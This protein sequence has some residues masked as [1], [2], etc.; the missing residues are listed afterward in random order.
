MAIRK[1]HEKTNGSNPKSD[2]TVLGKRHF[3]KPNYPSFHLIHCIEKIHRR[4]AI[5]SNS[6]WIA[7]YT[8]PP[9]GL[10]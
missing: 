7:E 1:A 5:E 9:L 6:V 8:P 2:R 3:K 10:Q 4:I